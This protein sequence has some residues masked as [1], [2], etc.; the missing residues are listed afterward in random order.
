MKGKRFSAWGDLGLLAVVFLAATLAGGMIMSMGMMTGGAASPAGPLMFAGYTVQFSLAVVCGM[1]WLRH[2]EGVSLRFGV[3]LSDA[4]MILS[5][6]LLVTA[7]SIVIEP[8]LTLFPDKYFDRLNEIIGRGGWAIL[9]TVVAAPV[10]EEIFF[11]GLL[12]E[13]LSRRWSTTAAVV[14]SAAFFGAVHAPILPQMVNA[15]VMAVIMG[16]IYVRTR[17][18]IPVI[19]I[20]A[21]NN[22]LAYIAL[23]LTG[24]QNTD[25]RELTGND[26]VYWVIYAVSS[27]ILIASLVLMAAKSRTKNDETALDKKTAYE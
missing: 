6:V 20:H 4:P 3:S 22:G 24:S 17:A 19:I 12:L 14:A 10:L 26:A 27:A 25:T 1:V 18:L 5:G 15:F 21:I 7:A 9:T 2:R 13:S 11:R 16:F 8:V 23:E